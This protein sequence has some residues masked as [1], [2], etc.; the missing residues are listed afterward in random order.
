ML[1]HRPSGSTAVI[2][3]AEVGLDLSVR[4]QTL[5]RHCIFLS[6]EVIRLATTFARKGRPGKPDSLSTGM[7]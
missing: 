2:R 7:E 5:A 6:N 4:T 1:A 3:C